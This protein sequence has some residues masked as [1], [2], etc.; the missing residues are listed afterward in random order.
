MKKALLTLCILLLSFS[1]TSAQPVQAP[2]AGGSYDD[3][4]ALFKEFR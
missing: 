1:W 4:V 2:A 3:L